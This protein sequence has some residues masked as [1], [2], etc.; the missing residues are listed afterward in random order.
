MK[1]NDSF[2]DEANSKQK[3]WV[4]WLLLVMS[5]ALFV[6]AVVIH[7]YW[8][9]VDSQNVWKSVVI[10]VVNA[11]ASLV[12]VSAIWDIF[13]KKSFAKKIL[14]LVGISNRLYQSGI[15]DFTARFEGE[16]D[17]NK[18]ISQ[19]DSLVVVFTYGA[20]WRNHNRDVLE[21]LL[22]RNGKLEVILPDYSKEENM[23]TLDRRFNYDNGETQKRIKEAA[24]FFKGLS[25]N[26]K[27]KKNVK[28]Y[29]FDGVFQSSYYLMDDDAIMATF[30]HQKKKKGSAPAFKCIKDSEL[31]QFI[32]KEIADIKN[33]IRLYEE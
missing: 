21:E 2:I 30:N 19:T 5:I 4:G 3:E 1:K 29:L 15:V 13:A 32:E 10:S 33:H 24:V 26:K 28:V 18:E 6:G 22:E 14:D 11:I 23:G 9:G 7:Y 25:D 16:I 17:W 27:Y 8:G 12:G 31:Y 20:T